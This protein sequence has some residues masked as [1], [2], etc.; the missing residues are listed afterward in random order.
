MDDEN[1]RKEV[2]NRKR[3]RR[4]KVDFCSVCDPRPEIITSRERVHWYLPVGVRDLLCD[5]REREM[6]GAK[7]K[8]PSAF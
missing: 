7:F 2:S 4:R 5:V 3:R 8:F 1:L 6:N